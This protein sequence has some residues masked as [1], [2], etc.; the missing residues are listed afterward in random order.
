MS[1]DE[2]RAVYTAE[3]KLAAEMVRLMLE[4]FNIPATLSQESVGSVYGLTVGPLGETQILVP[5]DKEQEAREILKDMEA[6]LLDQGDE[7]ENNK[8][9]DSGLTKHD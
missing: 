5:A 6:G 9:I 1:K 2:W 7:E 3:G 4:S 8:D